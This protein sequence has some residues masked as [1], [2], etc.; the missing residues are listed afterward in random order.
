MRIVVVGL[1]AILMS[2][3]L[4]ALKIF[5]YVMLLAQEKNTTI[6]SF[7]TSRI[8]NM[9]VTEL[10]MSKDFLDNFIQFHRLLLSMKP[11]H[12]CAS[13]Q[14]LE[15]PLVTGF[16][17]YT[18][19]IASFEAHIF[20]IDCHVQKWQQEEILGRFSKAFSFNITGKLK[21]SKKRNR[22]TTDTSKCVVNFL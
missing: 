9:Q 14:S 20:S 10:P 12:C 21:K 4:K 19:L 13:L 18:T 15:E 1:V 3:S 16:F 17:I 8:F 22:L 6:K 7:P 11:Q 2:L 5:I